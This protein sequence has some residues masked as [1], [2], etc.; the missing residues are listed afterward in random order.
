M[1]EMIFFLLF[2]VP[3]AMANTCLDLYWQTKISTIKS[4]PGSSDHNQERLLPISTR[5]YE[6]AD[7]LESIVQFFYTN[8]KIDS[9]TMSYYRDSA[10]D[11]A[12]TAYIYR[13]ADDVDIK[14]G[15]NEETVSQEVIG[16][17]IIYHTKDFFDGEPI[18]IGEAKYTDLYYSSLSFYPRD[19]SYNFIEYYKSSDT[20]Y[21]KDHD[22]YNTERPR[23][24][25][26]FF[27]ADS[28]DD[29]KCYQF[30]MAD[31]NIL[32]ESMEFVPTDSGYIYKTV[33]SRSPSHPVY[34]EVVLVLTNQEKTTF[35]KKRRPPLLKNSTARHYDLLG[36][37]KYRR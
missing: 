22:N 1:K 5:N 4:F 11:T 31:S 24:D 8:W 20:I 6:P 21:Y 7:S 17:T 28:L 37:F 2:M 32:I 14:G 13:D 25:N 23:T 29:M 9:L 19:S 35:I 10:I 16:D 15:G 34:S 12:Y 18:I 3:L 30:L 33:N 27:S 26:F 36:R